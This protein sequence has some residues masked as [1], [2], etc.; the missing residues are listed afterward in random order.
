MVE[1]ALV[2][3][4]E[5]G[6]CGFYLATD[7]LQ[8]IAVGLGEHASAAAHARRDG[9]RLSSRNPVLPHHG[10]THIIRGTVEITKL[11]NR[12]KYKEYDG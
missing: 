6:W 1:I 5:V 9:E 2:L 4:D 7:A 11:Y 8:R 12:R 10:L 3:R